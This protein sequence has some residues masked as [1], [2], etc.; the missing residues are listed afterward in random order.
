MGSRPEP[1]SASARGPRVGTIDELAAHAPRDHALRADLA[2]LGAPRLTTAPATIEPMLCATAAAPF[3]AEGWVFELKYDGFRLMAHAGAGQA[4]LRYRSG[5]EVTERFPEV[6]SA[7]RALPIADLVL[8]GEVVVLD[9]EGKPDFQRLAQRG[10]LTHRSEVQRAAVTQPVTYVVFDLLAASGHDLRGLPLLTRK[11][12]LARVV[13][14]VGPLRYADHIPARGEALLAEVVARGLEGIVGKRADAPYRSRRS[15]DWLKIKADPEADFAVCGYTPPRGA[16]TGL[17]ALHLC[18]RD[19]DAWRWAGKVGTGLDDELLVALAR[20]LAARP[21]WTPTFARPPGSRDARWVEPDLVV[22]VR[23]R[24]WPEAGALRHPV[25]VRARRDKPALACTMPLR[26]T[27]EARDEPGD[28]GTAGALVVDAPARE[29]RLSNLDK[30]FWRDEGITKGELIAYYRAIAPHL[31]PYLRDRPTVLHRYPDGI[32]GEMFYQK[33]MPGWAPPW[34]R[35]TA[36]WSEHGQREIHYVLLDDAD[37]LAY[38]ANLASIPLHCWASRIGALERPDWAILDLDP[39]Q[40]PRAHV[41]PLAR[42]I[43]RL[44]DAVGL[45]NYVKTS[46]QSG[47]HVLIPLGG[48]CTFDQAR[49]LAYVL[50]LLIERQHP[51]LA[52]TARNP[53]ARGGRVYLDWGQNAHGQLLAA[54]YSV[55]PVPGAS[56]SMPLTW[57]EVVPELE[58][59]A[60]HLR[61]AL[62]RVA[63]WREDPCRRVLDERPDLHAALDKLGALARD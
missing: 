58:P 6:A 36:L 32:D 42:A 8:D 40:A 60:F 61:N 55:R 33:D 19:G 44:C 34:L 37:G 18:V 63:G 9:D 52:T 5:R 46:G 16:R 41:V 17:G 31:L 2:A 7:L 30:P 62:D 25:F 47:L 50:A 39:K 21:R 10:H 53:A 4:T 26:R 14:S 56:V 3:S 57:D 43:H 38:V 23:Y 22:Q 35:T 27:G 59:R 48:Q 49:T 20:E 1:P 29:L 45:P 15:R 12:L 11:A 24:E 51:E 54:P 13:P 28:V